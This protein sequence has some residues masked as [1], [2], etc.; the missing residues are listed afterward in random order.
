MKKITFLSIIVVSLLA[1]CKKDLPT[2]GGTAA[3][4][5]ANEWW[6]TLDQGGTPLTP[7]LKILTYNTS[8]NNDSI[9]IDDAHNIWDVKFKAKANFND[10]TF[11]TTD[12]PNE[13]YPMTVTVTEGKILLNAGHSK[14]GNIVDSI[15][16]KI[17][18]SDD[19]VPGTIYDMN[20]T[21]RT[22]F[23]EDEY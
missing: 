22:R 21:A 10:L 17:Q 23:I 3:Q 1:S 12:S 2:I 15:H 7:H 4:K 13:I 6:V 14:S 5:L 18:F 11:S 20:G 9:W 19:P 16:M 8:A